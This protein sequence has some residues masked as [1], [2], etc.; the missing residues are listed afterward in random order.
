MLFPRRRARARARSCRCPALKLAPPAETGESRWISAR[1][2][3]RTDGAADGVSGTSVGVIDSTVVEEGVAGTAVERKEAAEEEAVLGAVLV[4]DEM[5]WTRR[6]ISSS[7]TSV[8]WPQGS[9]F[10]RSVPLARKASCKTIVIRDCA[11]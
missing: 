9:R 10:A 11:G 3:S 1:P 7:S 4:G 6:S 5:R 2:T 8:C